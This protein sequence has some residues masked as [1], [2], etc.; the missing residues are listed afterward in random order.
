M[1]KSEHFVW[2]DNCDGW[3]LKQGGKF[4]VIVEAMPPGTF[5]TKHFH[6]AVEQFFY[7]LEGILTMALSEEVVRLQPHESIT[8]LPS[9]S[10]Q[11]K[12]NAD[13]MLRFLVVSSSDPRLDRVDL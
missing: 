13:S 1:S 8:V 3:W 5:E 10:H 7:C 4:T 12:N 2:G 6:K 9:A 11:V